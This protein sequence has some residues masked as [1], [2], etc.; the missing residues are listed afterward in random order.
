MENGV[1]TTVMLTPE[2][3]HVLRELAEQHKVS[4]AWII[5]EA[6]DRLIADRASL[7]LALDLGSPR[8]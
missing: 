1:R 5:R 3:N 6:V 7:Q 2:Q 8:R 4:I